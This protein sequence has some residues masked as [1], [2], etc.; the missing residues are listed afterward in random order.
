VT[1]MAAKIDISKTL[2]HDRLQCGLDGAMRRFSSLYHDYRFTES[3]L[4]VN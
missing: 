2:D 4:Y 1:H 3:N